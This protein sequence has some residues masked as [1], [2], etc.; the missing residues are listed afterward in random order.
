MKILVTGNKG[1]IG[2]HIY[3]YLKARNYEVYGYDIGDTLEDVKYDFIIHMAA[4]GLIRLSK[5]YPYEY[6]QDGLALTMKFLELARKNNSMFIFPSSGSI[7][8]PTNPYSL[9]KKQAVEWIRLFNKLYNLNYFI[10][11]FFNIY[12][13]NAR[14]GAV[15]LFTRAALTG[16]TATVYGD[17]SHVRDYLYVGDVVKL[18]EDIINGRLNSGEYEVGS[19][20]GTSVNE[21]ISLIEDVT[22]RKI[23]FIRK[24]YVVDEADNLVAK[25]TV[26][27][28]PLPLKEGIERVMQW[29]KESEIKA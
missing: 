23:K 28:R 2:G 5:E 25:N 11:K 24:D 6:F 21:L 19:G 29:I 9:G 3:N 18:V 12:G 27:K 22:K 17:G 15:Y 7:E 14:K 4:R 8:N 20:I 13:E 1:F 16:E 10:L 26:I